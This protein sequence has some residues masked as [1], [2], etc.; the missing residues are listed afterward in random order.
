MR[1]IDEIL[2]HEPWVLYPNAIAGFSI[3]SETTGGRAGVYFCLLTPYGQR[4][5]QSLLSPG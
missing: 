2:K 4:N 3:L 1:E 5:R